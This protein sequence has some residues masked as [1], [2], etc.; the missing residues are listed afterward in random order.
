MIQQTRFQSIAFSVWHRLE[1]LIQSVDTLWDPNLPRIGSGK[2]NAAGTNVNQ[3]QDGGS[4]PQAKQPGPALRRRQPPW[5]TSGCCFCRWF[6]SRRN[7]DGLRPVRSASRSSGKSVSCY[8]IAW[9]KKSVLVY[10][11]GPMFLFF[12]YF[13]MT[14]H[15]RN[16]IVIWVVQRIESS[17]CNGS[18][19]NS[20]EKVLLALFIPVKAIIQWLMKYQ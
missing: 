12:W 6:T 11:G 7:C 5:T 4:A 17:Q 20:I 19:V 13:R 10:F 16:M 3:R 15:Y 2:E 1:S 9:N 8:S 18:M 14:T